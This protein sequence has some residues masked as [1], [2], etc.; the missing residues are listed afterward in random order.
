MLDRVGKLARG[1]G[2]WKRYA[3]KATPA[4]QQSMHCG[5]KPWNLSAPPTATASCASSVSAPVAPA[6][7]PACALHRHRLFFTY[8]SCEASNS[9][10]KQP[11][12]SD[13]ISPP[14]NRAKLRNFRLR[15]QGRKSRSSHCS[16][17]QSCLGTARLVPLTAPPALTITLAIACPALAAPAGSCT[18]TWQGTSEGRGDP[19]HSVPAIHAG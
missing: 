18:S 17:S 6:H 12:L 9:G 5:T 1:W 3:L 15:R 4:G 13:L 2:K 11:R 19:Q 8:S 14:R 7:H 10:I 16:C